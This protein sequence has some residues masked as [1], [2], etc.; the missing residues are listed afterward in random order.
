MKIHKILIANRGEIAIRIHHTLKRLG[1][2]TA[3]I[4]SEEDKNSYHRILLDECYFLGK[5]SL[6]DTY[7]NIDKI[8]HLA[9]QN[10]CDAIH[11]G[12]GFLSENDEFSFKCEQENILFIGPS[13]SKIKLMG[14]KIRSKEIAKKA[15]IPTLESITGSIEEI[16]QSIE[17]KL[18]K[19]PLL[20]KASA[21]GGGKGMKILYNDKNLKEELMGSQREAKNY[22][23]NDTIFV[24][25]YI[26]NPRHIEVQ[27][28][29]DT[30]GN[31][32]HLFERE[33]SIQRRH[34]KIL[35]E[36]PSPTLNEEE[37]NVLYNYAIKLAKEIEYTNA[38]TIEFLYEENT[39]NFY[40]LEMN[41]RI[42]VEH[43]VTEM[44]TG[45][46]IVEEQIKIALKEKL[47]YNQSQISKKGHAIEVRIYAEDPEHQFLPS[48]G[49]I[50][51]YIEPQ[52]PNIRID[53][54]IKFPQNISSYF[55]PM[56]SKVISWGKT[57]EESRTNLLHAL[58]NY[59]IHGVKTNINYLM[60][61]L[62]NETFIHNRFDTN[63]CNKFSYKENKEYLE[64]A[65]ISILLYDKLKSKSSTKSVLTNQSIWEYI[66]KWRNV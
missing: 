26:E 52:I 17:K 5:G 57:R 33:C 45:I 34:Q 46:D 13:S 56:I 25:K 3:G 11:P 6:L 29:G 54:S 16:I 8:I 65:L 66:G 53:S 2:K 20:I 15:G 63:F 41:T 62:Q 4:Y 19:F 64:E 14:D 28:L 44:I 61:I 59:I 50:L 55:D 7:L 24:E 49:N 32:I 21:G 51:T 22:F 18:I 42:Q 12:Y 10:H 30:Y 39:K 27:I 31:Y 47:S 48:P 23:G 1:F 37:R 9:K 40:F 38:G 58:K 60:D 36:A 43:P 35:E